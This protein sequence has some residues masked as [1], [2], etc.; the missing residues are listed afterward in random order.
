M[1]KFT[2]FFL[3]IQEIRWPSGDGC[4]V[5]VIGLF[6]LKCLQTENTQC[7]VINLDY[8]VETSCPRSYFAQLPEFAVDKLTLLVTVEQGFLK[9][10]TVL[11]RQGNFFFLS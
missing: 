9:V 10:G 6:S 1:G 5:P 3:P 2:F 7:P 11:I 8:T 4:H